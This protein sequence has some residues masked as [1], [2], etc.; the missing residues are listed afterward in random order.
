MHER[1]LA[2]Y[3]IRQLEAIENKLYIP[4]KIGAVMVFLET[5]GTSPDSRREEEARQSR[6]EEQ[7]D[8]DGDS[9][10]RES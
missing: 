8:G 9:I 7:D 3:H 5:F 10:L 1:A 6:R 4:S 2:R